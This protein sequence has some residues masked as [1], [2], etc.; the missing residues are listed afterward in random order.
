VA[1][2]DRASG[3]LRR[4]RRRCRTV[5]LRLRFDD[6]AR[7]T[8][9][10]TLAEPTA[11]T[12]RILTAARELLEAAQPMIE[13]RGITLVGVALSNLVDAGAPQLR[14]DDRSAALDATLDDLRD[15]F[16]TEAITR[17]VLLDHEE[18]PRLPQLPD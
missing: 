14:L 11:E 5:V 6:F 1:L 7:A 15:R 2:V 10:H 9:S 12:Q 3:R 13:R 8:R 16:G 4:A 17:A 18:G